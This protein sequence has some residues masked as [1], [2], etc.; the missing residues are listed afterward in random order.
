VEEKMW[1]AIIGTLMGFGYTLVGFACI[2][3]S[4]DNLAIFAC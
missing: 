4:V 1:I 3:V 2:R